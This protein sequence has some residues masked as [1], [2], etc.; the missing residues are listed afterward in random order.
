MSRNIAKCLN[1][2]DT[3]ESKSRHDWVTCRCYTGEADTHGF[4]LDGGE[5][6]GRYGGCIEDLEW[7]EGEEDDD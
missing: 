6:Y 1:C 7:L 3:V 5:E 2:G 4:F